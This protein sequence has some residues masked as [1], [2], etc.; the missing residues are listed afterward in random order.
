V[1]FGRALVDW[2][3]D[4]YAYHRS[5]YDGTT[6]PGRPQMKRVNPL[7]QPTDDDYGQEMVYIPLATGSFG[8]PARPRR[9][10]PVVD[11]P[12]THEVLRHLSRRLDTVWLDRTRSAAARRAQ[13]YEMWDECQGGDAGALARATIIGYIRRNLPDGSSD[14][15]T[16]QE[17]E[18]LSPFDPYGNAI[19]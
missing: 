3:D 17:L 11:P 4:P 12:E 2:T 16:R 10:V 8:G 1:N 9:I 13:L 14:A 18:R 15:F 6:E 5:M 7:A 19:P